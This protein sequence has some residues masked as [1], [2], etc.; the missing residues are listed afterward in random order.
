MQKP[1]KIRLV[2]MP[3]KKIHNTYCRGRVEVSS[4]PVEK[5]WEM[6]KCS[7]EIKRL[8]EGKV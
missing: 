3:F 7:A 4:T 8:K 2:A 6:T 1:Q 5:Q